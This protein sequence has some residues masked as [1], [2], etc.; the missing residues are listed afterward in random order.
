MAYNGDVGIGTTSPSAKVDV[1]G[2]FKYVDGNQLD[3]YVLLSDADG[4]ARWAEEPDPFFISGSLPGFNTISN[5]YKLMVPN[6]TLEKGSW[7]ISFVATYRMQNAVGVISNIYWDLSTSNASL[8]SV[9]QVISNPS[10]GVSSTVYGYCTVY[11][12]Y[13]VFPTTK[14]TYYMWAKATNLANGVN[15]DYS[16]EGKMWAIAIG[17]KSN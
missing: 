6:I 9:G 10:Q 8:V 4:Y 17:N 7:M 2:S 15:I 12:V 5:Q 1:R 11:A 14:V 16:G 3:N 13:L